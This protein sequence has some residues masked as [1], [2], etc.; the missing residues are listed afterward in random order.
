VV[1]LAERHVSQALDFHLGSSCGV[2]I[3]SGMPDQE[4]AQV[5]WEQ[6]TSGADRRKAWA[7]PFAAGKIS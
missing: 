2:K 4:V 3:A 1:Q 6:G 7:F 5:P